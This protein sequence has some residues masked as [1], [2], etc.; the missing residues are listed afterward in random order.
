MIEKSMPAD[1]VDAFKLKFLKHEWIASHEWVIYFRIW[2]SLEII[3]IIKQTIF[4]QIFNNIFE[5]IIFNIYKINVYCGNF[6][7]F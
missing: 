5:E 2:R 6:F 3:I 4:F 1:L 7:K